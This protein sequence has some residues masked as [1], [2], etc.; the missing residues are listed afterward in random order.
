V[1]AAGE[2]AGVERDDAVD[3]VGHLDR[4]PQPDRAAPVVDDDGG[5][6]Q[7]ELLEQRQHRLRVAV[8]AVPADVDR[9]VRTPE[10]RQVRSDA[11]VAGVAHGRQH[12]AP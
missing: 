8:I 12:L 6:T 11:P 2:Q 1:L 7:V 3:A 10:A 9:L 4:Y 5:A